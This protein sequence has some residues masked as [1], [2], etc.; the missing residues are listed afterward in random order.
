MYTSVGVLQRDAPTQGHRPE[1]QQMQRQLATDLTTAIT[2][3]NTLLD[4]EVKDQ[5]AGYQPNE[6]NWPDEEEIR[7]IL[8]RR[9]EELEEGIRLKMERAE[10]LQAFYQ[11]YTDELM[12]ENS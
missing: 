7:R 9:I 1:F 4:G 8:G 12:Y 3:F 5:F 2:T 11:Q 10:R 6:G